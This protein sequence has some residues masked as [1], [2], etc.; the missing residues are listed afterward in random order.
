MISPHSENPE[1][2]GQAAVEHV[3]PAANDM[4]E[5]QNMPALTENPDVNRE[6]VVTQPGEEAS[7]S[8]GTQGP[9]GDPAEMQMD[10]PVENVKDPP[11]H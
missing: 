9:D 2:T 8:M 3:N 7:H 6:D 1:M 5:A 10:N 11:V 4:V